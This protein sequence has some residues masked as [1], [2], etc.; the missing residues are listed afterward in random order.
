MP[1]IDSEGAKLYYEETGSGTSVVW[2]QEFAADYRPWEA[3]VRRP[4]RSD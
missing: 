4:Q 1:F 3:Q 2:I